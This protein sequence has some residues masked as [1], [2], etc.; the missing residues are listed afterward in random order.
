MN[1]ILIGPPGA[2]K[3]TQAKRLVEARHLPQYSTGDMLRAAIAA[4]SETG[5]SAKSYMD[6]GGLVPDE[7]VIGIIG[8]VLV[9][10][11]HGRGF[12][13]DGF[14]RTVA[15]AEALGHMLASQQEV[16][17]RVVMLDVS[18]EL[19]V[20]RIAGRWVCPADGSS[21]H[22]THS[23]PKTPSRCDRCGGLLV[24]RPDDVEGAVR[25][26]LAAYAQWTAPVADY[27]ARLGLLRR[28]D[29][30]GTPDEVSDRLNAALS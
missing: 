9:Q 8:D 16:I 11:G 5:L 6:N 23:P 17:D 1:I 25:K 7:V 15:Q 21:Y 30:V 13:L 20:D 28:I 4:G 22:V 2:G 10:A 12:I 29:G 3:G 19:I 24:Q 26:R 14:P 27:Y 18:P